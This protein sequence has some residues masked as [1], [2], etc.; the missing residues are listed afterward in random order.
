MKKGNLNN[1]ISSVMSG[2]F[3]LKTGVLDVMNSACV[4]FL[5]EH[6]INN[7]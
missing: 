6:T 3:S 7:Y 2:P 5:G 1:L 4:Y